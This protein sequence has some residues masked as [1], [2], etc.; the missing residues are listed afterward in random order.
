M[1]IFQ[2]TKPVNEG[3]LAKI[4][5]VVV[6]I[7]L[8]LGGV[9]GFLS[10]TVFRDQI[11]AALNVSPLP[12]AVNQ[13]KTEVKIISDEQAVIDAAKNSS[14]AVVSIV[15]SKDVPVYER[16]L[17]PVTD[18][19]SPFGNFF[20]PFQFQIP[21]LKEKGKHRQVIGGGTGFI[22]SAD[23]YIATN[24]HVVED[25]TAFYAVITT[26]GKEHGAKVLDRDPVND[27]AILKVEGN[28]FPTAELGDSDAI[29]IGQKAIAIGYALGEFKNTVTVGVISGLGRA[30]K[31]GNGLTGSAEALQ[32]LIQTD[33]A[34]NHGNSG[35]P[36]LDIRGH[37]VGVNVAIAEGSQNIG[38]AIPINAVKPVIESVKKNG[39]IIRPQLGVRY[40]LITAEIAKQKNLAADY[41]ALIIGG[42]DETQP[43]VLP[44]SPADK[45]GIKENDIIIE[46]NGAA[47][48]ET[49]N[50]GA[51]IVRYSVGDKITVK[52][53]RGSEEKI[54]VVA[55]EEWK[56]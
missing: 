15:V 52:V 19:Q 8:I 13:P 50:L 28:N 16:T 47:V 17:A 7:S 6:I 45:A 34:I 36:L 43:A 10:A 14:P 51:L 54:I 46:V 39:R 11:A 18:P 55:L 44:D 25:V 31:A 9:S 49:N 12:L 24:R 5:I 30:I 35:G 2:S 27:L 33:A 37:V 38:F 3:K 41:G 4:I 20:M 1:S 29:N 32:D 23:G 21:Q 42:K 48:N 22:V 26:D 56:K 53:L 40:V